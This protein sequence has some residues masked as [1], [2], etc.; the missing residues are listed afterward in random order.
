MNRPLPSFAACLI[1]QAGAALVPAAVVA[2]LGWEWVGD[3]AGRKLAV[4]AAA[5]ASWIASLAGAVPL[6][7]AL[8]TEPNRAV[9]AAL[10][11]TA[12][13]FL[14][15]LALAAPL[16]LG[17]WFPQPTFVA[18]LAAS[19]L[20]MLLVDSLVAVRMIRRYTENTKA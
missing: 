12:V 4:V 5:S 13:R 15:V 2:F 14:V 20:L 10:A 19:Y 17:G 3:D 9:N 7:L 1:K 8:S 18:A 16:L 6:A 11:S